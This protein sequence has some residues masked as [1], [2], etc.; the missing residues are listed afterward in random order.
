MTMFNYFL[1]LRSLGL[2]IKL[3]SN[4]SKAAYWF[5]GNVST[6]SE[7]EQFIGSCKKVLIFNTKI[8]NLL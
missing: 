3:D 5:S 6:T 1:C 2:A 7:T 4:I 8:N